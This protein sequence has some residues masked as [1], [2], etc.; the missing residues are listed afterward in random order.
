MW[1]L[2][3]APWNIHVQKNCRPAHSVDQAAALLC[4]LQLTHE[5]P[6]QP[7]P[8][9]NTRMCHTLARTFVCGCREK[10]DVSAINQLDLIAP[11]NNIGVPPPLTREI[12]ITS[13]INV[14]HDENTIWR[15]IHRIIKLP[16]P[17][18]SVLM[19]PHTSVSPQNSCAGS[20]FHIHICSLLRRVTATTLS[21][22][23][24]ED[25]L[26]NLR[27]RILEVEST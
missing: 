2:L 22:C 11:N 20:D 5:A 10:V 17:S 4:L 6:H 14:N 1:R 23:G 13:P 8:L 24:D 3:I 16:S 15:L 27:K 12:S 21:R 19:L 7:P 26:K 25:P 9:P 18:S